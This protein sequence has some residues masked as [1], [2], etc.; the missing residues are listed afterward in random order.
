MKNFKTIG[1]VSSEYISY[2]DG[3]FEKNSLKTGLDSFDFAVNGIQL[4]SLN[5]IAARPSMGKSTLALNLVENVT[6][7]Q[8]IPLAYFSLE[9]DNKDCVQS[10]FS[11]LN[12]I[13][14][15][16][17][18]TLRFSS[19]EL[20]MLKLSGNAIADAPLYFS[21]TSVITIEEICTKIRSLN[22]EDELKV[23]II[24]CLQLI[25]FSDP[26]DTGVSQDLS[27][28]TKVLRLLA[29]ELGIAIIVLSQVGSSVEYRNNKRPTTADLRLWG[30]IDED[31]SLIMFIYRDYIYNEDTP[32]KDDVELIVAKNDFGGRGTTL[33]TF[34]GKYSR[35]ED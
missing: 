12:N 16:I 17:L 34:N 26:K 15:H 23:V 29:E 25:H 28:M 20:N 3:N 19:Q 6:I 30:K 1:E 31:A 4:G 27:E 11:S 21:P 13:D 7:K 5:I 24:D 22:D 33:M 10:I 2:L 18:R 9:M 32:N 35:F 8:K 14:K